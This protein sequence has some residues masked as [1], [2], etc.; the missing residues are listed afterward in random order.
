VIRALF[1]AALEMNWDSRWYEAV[2]AQMERGEDLF[3]GLTRYSYSPLWALFLRGLNFVARPVGLPLYRAIG[4]VLLLTDVATALVVYAIARRSSKERPELAAG[5][6]L[7]FFLN[8]VSVLATG[9]HNQ[10]ENVSILFLLVAILSAGS[11]PVRPQEM[12]RGQGLRRSSLV[13]AALSGSLP[14]SSSGAVDARDSTRSPA[15]Y[16]TSSSLSRFCPT[17]G[18]GNRW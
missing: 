16:P 11:R 5:A 6:A 18:P 2:V 15:S 7:L 17:G 9:H 8:P 10:F 3:H 12:S 1:F 4:I 13:V 14:C